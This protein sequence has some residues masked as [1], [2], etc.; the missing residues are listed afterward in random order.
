M[1]AQD[2]SPASGPASKSVC[3]AVFQPMFEHTLLVH[4]S[5]CDPA[6]MVFF[7]QYFVMLNNCVELWFTQGLH[8]PYAQLVAKR[9]V[10]LPTVH[11]VSR[12]VKPSY[13]GERITFGCAVKRL[14]ARSIVLD[15]H[16][17]GAGDLA[18]ARAIFEQTLVTT[19]LDT[20]R[21]IAVP[22]DIVAAF[23]RP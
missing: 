17:Y 10:G 12:F 22:E 13:M 1:T 23:K 21:A 3:E 16:V 14:G 4:F 11:L 18:D 9:R 7:P 20:H 5:H 19:S 8:I 15:V 6:G 2:H